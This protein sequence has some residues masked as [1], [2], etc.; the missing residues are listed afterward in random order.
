MTTFL[1]QQDKNSTKASEYFLRLYRELDMEKYKL[2]KYKE[3]FVLA[4]FQVMHDADLAYH[5][6]YHKCA[7]N[8]WP[9]KSL[10][11]CLEQQEKYPVSHPECFSGTTFRQHMLKVINEI[12]KQLKSGALDY[13]YT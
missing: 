2:D 9:K 4:S 11:D 13:L 5:E 7:Q 6:V 8:A 10:L 3:L 12:R 1:T